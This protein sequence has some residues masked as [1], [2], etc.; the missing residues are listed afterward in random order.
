MRSASCVEKVKSGEIG[1]GQ[2]FRYLNKLPTFELLD[3][4]STVNNGMW[5]LYELNCDELTCKIFEE[6]SPN[7]WTI[8]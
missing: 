5:R 7:A 6:F 8:N 1:I 2:L 4:G 3:A